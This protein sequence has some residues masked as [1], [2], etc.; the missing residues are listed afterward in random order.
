VPDGRP[1]TEEAMRLY[2]QPVVDDV[3]D[4]KLELEP[5]VDVVVEPEPEV[6][7]EPEVDEPQSAPEPAPR[8]ENVLP[9]IVRSAARRRN[10][11][12]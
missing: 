11:P 10:G 5:E 6:D 7:V 1:L 12:Q 2:A 3:I 8:S 4:L 9:L